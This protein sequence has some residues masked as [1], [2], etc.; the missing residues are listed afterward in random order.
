MQKL[1]FLGVI[2]LFLTANLAKAND[3][4]PKEDKYQYCIKLAQNKAEKGFEYA[5]SWQGLS[6]GIAADH[7]VATALISLG[8]FKEAAIRL[9]ALAAKMITN[10][11]SQVSILVQSGHAWL[12]TGNHERANA[13]FTTALQ[14]RPNDVDILMDRAQARWVAQDYMGAILDLNFAIAIDS[15][16]PLIFVFRATARRFLNQTILARRDINQALKLNPNLVQGLLE[17]GIL[18]R[19]DGD[20]DGARRDWVRTIELQPNTRE[21]EV[22]RRNLEMM[23][24]QIK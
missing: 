2:N 14:I 15:S 22:A 13:V 19:L 11:D 18:R 9:E 12:L 10:T 1:I 20:N 7:C 8:M 24:I 16:R 21:A 3:V 5:L 6:G 17:R 4:G 23:D